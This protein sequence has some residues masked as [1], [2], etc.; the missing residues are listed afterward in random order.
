MKP[1]NEVQHWQKQFNEESRQAAL[2]IIISNQ[3]KGLEKL[4][5]N[6]G[7]YVKSPM[8][9]NL[10]VGLIEQ[11]KYWAPAAYQIPNDNINR[12][13][14]L[15]PNPDGRPVKILYGKDG[16]DSVDVR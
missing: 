8:A 4:M 12:E 5:E 2:D 7:A 1:L 6:N 14:G 13:K 16:P 9:Y 10:C 3:I 11:L 15:P